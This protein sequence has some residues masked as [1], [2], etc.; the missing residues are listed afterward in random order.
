MLLYCSFSL[1]T[2]KSTLRTGSSTA[3][4]WE[5]CSHAC[6]LCTGAVKR[7]AGRMGQRTADTV[8]PQKFSKFKGT[9]GIFWCWFRQVVRLTPPRQDTGSLSPWGNRPLL[10][11]NSNNGR[12]QIIPGLFL[13][14]T[15]LQNTQNYRSRGLQYTGF[16][17]N[18]PGLTQDKQPM[19]L[20]SSSLL[21]LFTCLL[22]LNGKGQD[23]LHGISC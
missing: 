18:Q 9:V 12:N 20:H 22:V 16:F 7:T 3:W 1:P 21:E 19:L 2:A 13:L 23:A 11:E 15:S 14:A 5:R 6:L 4:W 17:P 8:P 10:P